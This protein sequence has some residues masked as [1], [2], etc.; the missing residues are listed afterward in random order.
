MITSEPWKEEAAVYRIAA[1]W[2]EACKNL[3]STHRAA[4][5]APRPPE[6]EV[7]STDTR[8]PSYYE[9]AL[10]NRQVLV[11]FVALLVCLLGAFLS[12][13]WVG[14]GG[15]PEPVA[16]ALPPPPAEQPLEQL[17]FFNGREAGA[18]TGE[19]SATPPPAPAPR[20]EAA[21][22]DPATEAMRR[23]LEA[24]MEANREAPATPPAEAGSRI[25]RDPRPEAP[26]VAAVTPK[27]AAATPKPA[28][29]APKPATAT[30]KPASAAG[31][32]WVQVY[33]ST[34]G[35]RAR[36]IVASLRK[37]KFPVV[38]A[39]VMK[40]GA[41]LQ[42]VRVGPFATRERADTAAAK[43]RREHRLDTWI[44]DTP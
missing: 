30:P 23:T 3:L 43:L 42:R 34:N 38:L 27:P 13:V 9:V 15:Q 8:E 20:A 7:E 28:T 36:E 1:H 22:A 39:E 33:S 29:A 6:A 10:T 44:T 41:A 40:D 24:E 16:T 14:Q 21:P 37:A 11:A 35:E 32:V 19:K 18:R 12:G 26:A 17:T 4:R 25:A 5:R 2:S 31:E